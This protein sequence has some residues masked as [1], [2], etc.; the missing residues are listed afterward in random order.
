MGG[1]WHLSWE[2]DFI[3]KE[4]VKAEA[5]NTNITIKD[6][7]IL[8]DRKNLLF[9]GRAAFSDYVG[10]PWKI[11]YGN[12]SYTLKSRDESTKK[13]FDSIE[14]LMGYLKKWQS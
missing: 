13:S 4:E 12:G 3:L 10:I 7:A 5:D 14:E 2:K 8:D 11:I 9:G 6:R 1:G